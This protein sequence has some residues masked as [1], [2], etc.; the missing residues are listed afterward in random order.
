MRHSFWLK[1]VLLTCFFSVTGFVCPGEVSA[2]DGDDLD[3]KVATLFRARCVNCHDDRGKAAG[4]GVDN[5]LNFSELA[6]GY[7][8]SENT[9][10]STLLALTVGDDATMPRKRYRD[11]E[12]NGP[13][14]EAE[15][16][17]L[18]EWILR[19]GPSDEYRTAGQASSRELISEQQVVDAIAAD[20]GRLQGSELQHARYLTL[21][22]LHNHSKV[23]DGDLEICRAAVVKTLNSLSQNSDVLGLDTS[24]AVNRLVAADP[25]RTIFRFDLRHIGWSHIEWDRLSRHYP[26]AVIHRSGNGRTLYT[27]TS[28]DLPYLRADWF[29]FAA[30]QPPLYHDLAGIPSTLQELEQKLGINRTQAVRQRLVDRAGMEASKVSVNNRLLERI[31]LKSRAGAFHISDD[32][33]SNDG[34]QNF[35][36]NPL[37]PPGVFDTQHAYRQDGGEVIFNL[38]NGFQAYAVVTGKGDRLNTAPQAIVSDPTMP[39]G[40]IING[41][42]CLSC[43]IHGMKPDIGDSRAATLDRVREAALMNHRRFS[44]PERELISELYPAQEKFAGL[45]EQDRRRFLDALKLAGIE[46]KGGSEPARA[47]FD[48]FVRDLD[49]NTVAAE[50]AMTAD[51]LTDLLN[52][53]SE[54]RQMLIRIQR[55]SLKR[56][57]YL[58]TFQEIVRLSLG[59]EPRPFEKLP[60]PYFGEQVST[61]A[62]SAQPAAN[63]HQSTAT[64]ETDGIHRTGVDLIDAEHQTGQL[65]VEMWTSDEQRSYTD[66]QPI[67]CHVRATEDCFLTIVSVDSAGDITLLLPNRWHPEFRVKGGQTVTIPTRNMGF[68]FFATEPHGRTLL[69]VI[70]TKS[71]LPLRTVSGTKSERVTPEM[72]KDKGLVPLANTKAVALREQTGSASAPATESTPVPRTQVTLTDAAL[73]QTFRPQEWATAAWTLMTRK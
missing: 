43:H 15:Q 68:E 7:I 35:F 40:V 36:D 67:V 44:V 29:V 28:S 19:G 42:S 17:L 61:T 38:P 50:F 11:V 1:A 12:W 55:N 65:K 6:D 59:A 22:N 70:A 47:L 32:F 45:L 41:I 14:T 21:C 46:Q 5:L 49:V 34:E 64:V 24:A 31:A 56:Q 60:S 18:K 16:E 69:K 4:G 13:L 48:H 58:A 37:G 9:A 62:S 63:G 33:G 26:Y 10:D 25:D 52:R 23:S 27:Q 30:L 39:G 53:E 8:D 54:T 66:G 2:D 72:L 20:M 3:R 57:L 51:A 71:P 73:E